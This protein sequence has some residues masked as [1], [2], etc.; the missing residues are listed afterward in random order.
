MSQYRSGCFSKLFFGC[1]ALFIV[2]FVVIIAII[3]T[4]ELPEIDFSFKTEQKEY[5]IETDSLTNERMVSAFFS[6]RF[7]DNNL[8]KRRYDL[9]F[10]LLAEDVNEAM[11]YVNKLGKMNYDELGLQIDYPDPEVEARI[12]WAEI[13]RRI[14]EQALPKMKPILEGFN[15]IFVGE[16]F[17]SRDKVYFVISFIQNISYERP[18]GTLDLLP[19]LGT[20]AKKYGDCDSKALLLYVILERMGVDCAM[21]WSYYYKHAMLG[22]NIAGS[23]YYKNLEGKRYYFL[24]TTYPGW[25]IGEVPPEFDNTRYWFVEE[26]DSEEWM[27]QEE[28]FFKSDKE[29]VEIPDYSTKPKPAKPE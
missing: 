17:D 12:V 7:V 13:Y 3:V 11:A 9:T 22:V 20:L 1:A 29:D 15:K 2:F 5:K 23:G 21:M 14:Y 8:R 27:K 28:E 18:G 4:V 26:I 16:K 24:E 10:K 25:N 19:P 6:W